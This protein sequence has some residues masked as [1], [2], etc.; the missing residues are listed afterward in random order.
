M[1]IPL[2]LIDAPHKPNDGWLLGEILTAINAPYRT[3]GDLEAK[4]NQVIGLFKRLNVRMLIIDEVSD[5]VSGSRV[6]QREILTLIKQLSTRIGV[7]I[8]LT[9]VP[10]ILSALSANDQIDSRFSKRVISPWDASKEFRQLLKAIEGQTPLKIA[11]DLAAPENAAMMSV[12]LEKSKGRIGWV[13]EII[14]KSAVQAIIKGTEK[15]DLKIVNS[16]QL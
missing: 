15:I 7:A 13:I 5:L 6:R 1:D 9:G 3:K 12:I 4:T 14:Q 2:V 10:T 8:V 16:V 11:S